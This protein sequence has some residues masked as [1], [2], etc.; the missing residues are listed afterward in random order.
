MSRL[1]LVTITSLAVIVYLI[2]NPGDGGLWSTVI[3]PT[4]S[5]IGLLA[6]CGLCL[7]NYATLL[8]VSPDSP[9]GWIFPACYGVVIVAG[10]LWGL[11]LRAAR[12]PAYQQ[13]G[14]GASV[15][16]ATVAVQPALG[17]AR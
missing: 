12:H 15:A 9:L 11:I 10:L 17:S 14:N 1:L 4:L 13:I 5:A 3:A 16:P 7:A 6:V 8:G 2:R